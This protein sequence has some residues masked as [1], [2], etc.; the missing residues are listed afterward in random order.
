MCNGGGKL[1]ACVLQ[2]AMQALETDTNSIVKVGV[3][4]RAV[5]KVGNWDRLMEATFSD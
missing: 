2:V 1:T 5:A 3:P 4:G